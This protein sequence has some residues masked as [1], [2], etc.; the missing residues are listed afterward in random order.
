MLTPAQVRSPGIRS[1]ALAWLQRNVDSPAWHHVYV[2]LCRAVHPPDPELAEVGCAHL[3]LAWDFPHCGHILVSILRLCAEQDRA[4]LARE[5]LSW[6]KTYPDAGGWGFLARPVIQSTAADEMEALTADIIRWLPHHQDIA[7]AS[8]VLRAMLAGPVSAALRQHVVRETQAWLAAP[9][10]G[11][12]HVFLD[13]LPLI[14]DDVAAAIA[15]PWLTRQFGDNRWGAVLNEMVNRLEASQVANIARAWLGQPTSADQDSQVGFM[16]RILFEEGP[17]RELLYDA[18]FREV[19]NAWLAAHGQLR[20]WWHI[21]RETYKAE[22]TDMGPL[23][24]ALTA[25]LPSGRAHGVGSLVGKII[26]VQPELADPIWEVMRASSRSPSWLPVFL[27]LSV[28]APTPTCWELGLSHL[29]DGLPPEQFSGL[30]RRLWNAF[31]DESE[32]GTLRLMAREWLTSNPDLDGKIKAKLDDD[33]ARRI[34]PATVFAIRRPKT[35]G[36]RVG[37]VRVDPAPAGPMPPV[38]EVGPEFA[39]PQCGTPIEVPAAASG[40]ARRHLCTDCDASLAVDTRAGTVTLLGI[41]LRRPAQP[42]RFISKVLQQVHCDQCGRNLPAIIRSD[43]TYLAVDQRCGYLHEVRIELVER[44]G[45]GVPG[46][47]DAGGEA[48]DG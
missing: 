24:A 4:A 20:S 48:R 8:Y 2:H 44:W 19:I 37:T 42:V 34:T 28:V 47:T 16:W 14:S 31:S 21:W 13:V 32:R 29:D 46:A 23:Q 30:W 38:A 17:C 39:C 18:A 27:G 9:H 11:W 43:T 3:P 40:G 26:A 25:D 22:P 12:G 7:G 5:A 6:M 36:L 10:D 1:A 15:V 41:Y 33:A 45:E 35:P